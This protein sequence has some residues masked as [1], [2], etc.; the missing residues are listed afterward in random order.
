MIV[1]AGHSPVVT[2]FDF[3]QLELFVPLHLLYSHVFSVLVE[4]LK[5]SNL[6][7]DLGDSLG[8]LEPQLDGRQVTDIPDVL[9]TL[10]NDLRNAGIEL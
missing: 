6:L 9:L 1:L 8:V 5:L 7:L 10:G 4:F 3:S 2:N